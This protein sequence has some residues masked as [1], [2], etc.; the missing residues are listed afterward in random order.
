MVEGF[1]PSP[2]VMAPYNPP[3]YEAHLSDFGLAKV[4]DLLCWY[5]SAAEGYR[6]RAVPIPDWMRAALQ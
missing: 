3:Y 1:K 2:V 5:I 6:M 4:K